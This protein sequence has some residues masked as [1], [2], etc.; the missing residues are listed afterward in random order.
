MW[1]SLCK[2]ASLAAQDFIHDVKCGMRYHDDPVLDPQESLR[3]EH[4]NEHYGLAIT[5]VFQ[6]ASDSSSSKQTW[7][8]HGDRHL[9]QSSEEIRLHRVQVG[10]C[11]IEVG[12]G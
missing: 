6:S 2:S 12:V 1:T 10:K 4:T 3:W 7:G 8:R 9:H 5:D 11:A